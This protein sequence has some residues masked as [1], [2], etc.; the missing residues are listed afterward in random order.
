MTGTFHPSEDFD[1]LP[2]PSPA[3]DFVEHYYDPALVDPPQE[4]WVRRA[5]NEAKQHECAPPVAHG[6]VLGWPD[7]L[8]SLGDLWRC[9]CGS[10]WRV[11]Y[12]CDGCDHYGEGRC[13]RGHAMHRYA[14]RPATLW[15]RIR[16]RKAMR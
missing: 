5:A 16:Y 6:P 13:G 14:W 12:R 1:P 4:G 9:R 10:L 11:G 3:D 8:G 2:G 7:P 15:Q